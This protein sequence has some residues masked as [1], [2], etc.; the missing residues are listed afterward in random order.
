MRLGG[1]SIRP[2]DCSQISSGHRKF[3]LHM[4][5]ESYADGLMMNRILR[6][7]HILSIR[8]QS[9]RRSSGR[10]ASNLL[11]ALKLRARRTDR[12]LDQI[13]NGIGQALCA[14]AQLAS[15]TRVS[16]QDSHDLRWK[17]PPPV[18]YLAERKAFEQC[19]GILCRKCDRDAR[20]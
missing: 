5:S 1:G 15:K 11:A 4:T 8:R 7:R 10:V 3:K 9:S 20:C 6:Q 18:T 13:L 16:S 2:V 12:A 14:V 17:R 19:G